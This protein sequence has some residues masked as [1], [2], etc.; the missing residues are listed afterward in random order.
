LNANR[1]Q[2]KGEVALQLN[3]TA[4]QGRARSGPRSADEFFLLSGMTSLKHLVDKTSVQ[5]IF[6]Q[7]RFYSKR[8]LAFQAVILDDHRV[9]SST[10]AVNIYKF[11]VAK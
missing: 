5:Q 11:I 2:I 4:T 10:L 6:A 8:A 7:C 3:G 1:N 9:L